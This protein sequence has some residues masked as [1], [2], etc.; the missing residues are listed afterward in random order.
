MSTIQ[1]L[2]T[3]DSPHQGTSG[4]DVM[5]GT[6]GDDWLYGAGGHDKIYGLE[7]ND[8]LVA[9]MIYVNGAWQSDPAGDLLDGGAGDDTIDGGGGWDTV[10]VAAARASVT[11][12]QISGG[13]TV[14]S[15]A[16]GTDTVMNVERI[17]FADVAVAFDINSHA[18]DVYRLYQAAFDRH[19]DLAG[20]GYW[21]KAADNGV[22]MVTMSSAFENSPEFQAKYGASIDNN[23][24]LTALYNNV[25]H[26]AYDQAGFDYWMNALSNGTSREQALAYFADGSENRAQVI[27]SIQAGI[28]YTPWDS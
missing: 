27:G 18:G 15:A 13:F 7:G 5:Q 12:T 22:S 21:I 1:H 11:V 25:L 3:K 10:V 8:N 2:G 9:G 23:A 19:P 14:S 17:R 4:D 26:R 28:E 16:S 20:L 24:F 6:S